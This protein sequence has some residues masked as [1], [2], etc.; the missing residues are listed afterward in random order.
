[1]SRSFF[2]FAFIDMCLNMLL[3]LLCILA[4]VQVGEKQ[5]ERAVEVQLARMGSGR[6]GS[7][8]GDNPTVLT[9][10]RDGSLYIGPRPTSLSEIDVPKDRMVLLR[11]DR[12]VLHAR[13]I[14][15]WDRLRERGCHL[16]SLAVESSSPSG[17]ELK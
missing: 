8:Q 14:E 16:I 3:N 11:P 4:C 10:K 2:L 5:Q 7:I 12:D 9:I 6:T 15:V 1:M 13:V 17:G